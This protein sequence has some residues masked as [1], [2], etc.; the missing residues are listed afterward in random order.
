MKIFEQGYKINF[1]D[2]NNVLVG[3]DYS[4][5]CCED[6]GWMISRKI[7]LEKDQ[8][9]GKNDGAD[10]FTF[11]TKFMETSSD[12]DSGGQVSFRL[13]SDEGERFLTLWNH[14]NGYYSHGFEMLDER[15]NEIFEGSL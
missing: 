7:P 3:F 14:H 6:F 4:Q 10:G 11:D 9:H 1:V 15:K 2:D 13:L 5:S 8:E 12:S